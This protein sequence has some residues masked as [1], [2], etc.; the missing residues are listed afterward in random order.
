[1]KISGAIFDVDGTLLDSMSIW[2]AIGERYLRSLG[3]EP[4]ENLNE[5]FNTMSLYQ[6][7]CYYQSEYGV[8][9]ST[10]EIMRG[11]NA[12]LEQ[13]YRCEVPL[14]PGAEKL[15]ERLHQNKAKLC[16]ATATDRYLVEVALR[17]CGVRSYFGELFTCNEVG[18]GKDEPHIFEAALRFLGT[19]R[20]QTI[21][22]DDALYALR[23]AKAA[24]FPVAAV[25]DSHENAQAEV[26]ALA[27]VYLENLADFDLV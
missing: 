27:D 12:L 25:Y 7:A 24:G 10:D 6:A 20:A 3:Y 13:Q 18:H 23:T 8:T 5:V 22:F 16:I 2:D 9:L 26:Q 11:V 19:E 14:K 21:V 17:R 15:L 4:K 1:M